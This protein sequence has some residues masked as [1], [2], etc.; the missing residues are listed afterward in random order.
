MKLW[1]WILAVF[2]VL[3]GANAEAA[4]RLGGGGSFGKQ[5]SNVTQ[6]QAAPA[7]GAAPA[8]PATALEKQEIRAQLQCVARKERP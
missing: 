8:K 7:Q 5:S 6:R 4:R 3:A 1:T 2:L